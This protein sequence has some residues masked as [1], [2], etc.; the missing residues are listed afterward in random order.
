LP[1]IGYEALGSAA[2]THSTNPPPLVLIV[3]CALVIVAFI[4][5]AF[6]V[7]S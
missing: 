3:S 2:K 7:R 4:V 6:V 5:I 1:L